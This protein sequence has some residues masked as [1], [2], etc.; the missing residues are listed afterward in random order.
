MDIMWCKDCTRDVS[1]SDK[2]TLTVTLTKSDKVS[3]TK[4][5]ILKITLTKCQKYQTFQPERIVKFRDV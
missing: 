3:V 5:N 1:F 2:S 4:K